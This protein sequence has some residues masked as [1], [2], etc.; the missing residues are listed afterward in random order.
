MNGGIKAFLERMPNVENL[1]VHVKMDEYQPWQGVKKF[2]KDFDGQLGG[3]PPIIEARS[4]ILIVDIALIK[5]GRNIQAVNE[6][7]FWNIPWTYLVALETIARAHRERQ[8]RKG[9]I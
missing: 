3:E 6:I 9:C 4:V 2:N 5:R 7:I 1:V 8:H